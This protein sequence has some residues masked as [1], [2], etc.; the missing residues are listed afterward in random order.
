MDAAARSFTA[1]THSCAFTEAGFVVLVHDHR[2]FGLSGGDPRQDINPWQQMA[3]WRRAISFLEARADVD[4]SR[5]GLWGTSYAGS[6]P[7]DC[8]S[9][10]GWSAVIWFG[11][12]VNLLFRIAA[13]AALV[14]GGLTAAAALP[15]R[16]FLRGRE[17]A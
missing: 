10:P 15:R 9:L 7:D 16:I 11:A 4:A 6:H 1:W 13:L 5:I 17:H 14:Y 12:S 8:R 2:G 3:G